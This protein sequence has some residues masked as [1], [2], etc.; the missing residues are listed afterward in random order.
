LNRTLVAAIAALLVAATFGAGY[1]AGRGA[2]QTET[3]TV[4]TSQTPTSGEIVGPTD[5]VDLTGCS[6]SNKTCTFVITSLGQQS[7]LG[8]TMD[9]SNMPC[10]T[11]T[12]GSGSRYSS[13]G[14]ASCT[15][16]PSNYIS[17]VVVA[18]STTTLT[19]SFP[20]FDTLTPP[21]VGQSVYG[22]IRYTAAI[23]SVTDY[24]CLAFLGVFTP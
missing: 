4:T 19:A 21:A 8:I 18:G 9:E 23:G 15:Y 16:S 22:C 20:P 13:N 1:F 24:G 2:Q 14:A 7:S 10:V 11:L 17:S 6:I 3:V 12:Y 5:G